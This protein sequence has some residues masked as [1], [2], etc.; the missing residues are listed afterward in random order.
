[1]SAFLDL[2]TGPKLALVVSLPSNDLDMAR[3][4]L[5]NG[6]DAIKV[7]AN[8]WHR[9]SGHTFG[10]FSE[11]R[12]FLETLIDLAGSRPVG[13]VPGASEAFV[14][15]GEFDDLADMGL[16]FFSAYADDLP[17]FALRP[18]SVARMVAI[19][20]DYTPAD[21]RGIRTWDAVDVVEVSVMPG[22]TYGDPLRATDLLRYRT[23]I[24]SCGK[25][26][27]VPTQRAVT[28]DEVWALRSVGFNALMIGAVV[29]DSSTDPRAVGAATTSFR[30][31]IDS[32]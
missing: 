9:A 12:P 26:A 19:H 20:D 10:T 16:G 31:S 4:A 15:P 6:A 8:V 28:P 18:S 24:D 30:T 23:I 11:Q 1:M 5:D 27:L 13:L 3:A 22:S 32:L 14:T 7:H 29:M 21:L 25:P 17:P 2:L